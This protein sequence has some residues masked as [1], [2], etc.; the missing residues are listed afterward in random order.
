[1][2][3]RYA[4]TSSSE[5]ATHSKVMKSPAESLVL[6]SGT[7]R[8]PSAFSTSTTIP[9]AGH[10]TERMLRPSA[11]E[12]SATCKRTLRFEALTRA[13]CSFTIKSRLFSNTDSVLKSSPTIKPMPT[14]RRAG[15]RFWNCPVNSN[16][17]TSP[18]MGARTTVVK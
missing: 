8:P 10:S 3:A 18:V 17:I 13:F 11:Y 2:S 7:K 16:I 15:R 1:M 9:P 4:F 6:P 5:A 14:P 12:P